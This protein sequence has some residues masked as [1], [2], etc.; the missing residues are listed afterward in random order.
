MLQTL[1]DYASERLDV[2]ETRDE[3]LRAHAEWVLSLARTVDFG[4]QTDGAIVA[5]VQDEDVAIRDAITWSLATD[6][7]LALEICGALSA[8]WFGT[9]RV[10]VGWEWLSAALFAAD[11]SDPALRASASAWATVFATMVQDIATAERHADNAL[12]FERALGD[13]VRLGKICFALALAAGYRS[14]RDAAQWIAETRRHF[15]DA[16]LPVG[17]GHASFAEG[18]AHLVC[19]EI[20]AAAVSLRSSITSFREHGDHLGLIL[21]VSR[22]G[23]LASRLGDTA[24]FAEMHAELLELGLASR[25]GGVIAGA[26]ARLAHARLIQGD[27]EEAQ[28]LARTALASSSESFMPIVNGY[29]FRSAGLVNLRLG[30]LPEGRGHLRAAIE[31]FEQGAGNVGVGQ[32][33]LCWI[34][35]SES[36]SDTGEA[37]AALWAAERAVEIAN[38]AGDPWVREQAGAQMALLAAGTLAP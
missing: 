20:D 4:A 2:R 32:A 3:T 38:A 30:H 28:R 22:L 11:L 5:S 15:A 34:D 9:M 23:E 14:D 18:A 24:L 33:A 16:G 7:T 26:T 10:S 27:I 1:A 13:P 29:A 8:F 37:D 21:A 31:A 12:S 35:L 36:C 25:S 6:P 19:G 17:L